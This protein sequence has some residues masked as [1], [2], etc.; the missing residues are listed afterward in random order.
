MFKKLCALSIM[1][2]TAACGMDLNTLHVR[3]AIIGNKTYSIPVDD[4]T[5]ARDVLK[6]CYA[7]GYQQ[8][9][10]PVLLLSDFEH[11]ISCRRH[12][13]YFENLDENVKKS[14]IAH[15]TNMADLAFREK[16]DSAIMPF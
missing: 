6:A 14:M 7:Q 16:N 10:E 13:K 15:A 1:A 2:A 9:G 5:K 12:V 11:G 4:T 8:K 3:Y